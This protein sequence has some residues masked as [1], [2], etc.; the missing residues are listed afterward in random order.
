MK[1]ENKA[2][3]TDTFSLLKELSETPGVSGQEDRIRAR[4]SDHLAP[5][6]DELQTDTLGNLTGLKRGHS[7]SA[8]RVML[9]AHMDE[10]GL[11]VT[12]L[13]KGF[14]R[15]APVGGVDLG[16]LP[17][18]EVTVHG[19]SDL[20]GLIASRPPHVLSME[21]REK[22]FAQVD[23]FI[24]VGLAA[25]RLAEQVSVGDFISIR[26]SADS[27]GNGHATGKAFDNRVSVVVLLQA[28]RILQGRS[29]GWEVVAAVT[30]QEEIGLRGA[31]T[32]TFHVAPDVGIALDVTYAEQPGASPDEALPM[33][34]GP[35][36]GLGPN[37][38]PVLRRLLVDTAERQEIPYTNEVLPG[39]SGTDAWA[40]Q[41]S[42]SGIPTA[43]ISVPI[44][45][46]HTPAETVAL[47]DIDRSARLLAETIC[48]LP[49][50]MSALALDRES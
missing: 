12:R 11:I 43:L 10:I 4:V 5:L 21:E 26:R 46:M 37:M 38:H 45:N 50:D 36:I 8:R 30:V 34:S 7:S 42:Q 13:E 14:L 28:L 23:L 33:G 1:S 31:K 18:Q 29:H 19:R 20:P 44:R 39:N 9:A 22:P 3:E 48:E 17:A 25:D 40:M 15:F 24:D 27:L 32:A 47:K 2:H 49:D 6:V 16:A 41:V 35:A